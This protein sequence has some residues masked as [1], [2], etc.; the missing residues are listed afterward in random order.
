MRFIEIEN[1]K[2]IPVHNIADVSIV[3][4]GQIY[5]ETLDGKAYTVIVTQREQELFF[6]FMRDKLSYKIKIKS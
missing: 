6:N 4:P 5:I 1:G 2:F 3:H